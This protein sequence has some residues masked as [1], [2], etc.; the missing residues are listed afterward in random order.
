MQEFAFEV[1]QYGLQ[2]VAAVA[3]PSAPKIMLWR[4]SLS[5]NEEGCFLGILSRPLRSIYSK[6]ASSYAE[7]NPP[8]PR[9][10]GCVSACIRLDRTS[11]N[12]QSTHELTCF[13]FVILM[14]MGT[15]TTHEIAKAVDRLLCTAGT[16]PFPSVPHDSPMELN[17]VGGCARLQNFH[18]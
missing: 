6:S 10:G 13:L 5:R 4:G 2:C 7:P 16:I 3:L 18:K 8:A 1:A 17:C 14:C 9:F 12:R 11:P 15:Q